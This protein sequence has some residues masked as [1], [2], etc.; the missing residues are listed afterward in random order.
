MSTVKAIHTDKAPAAIGPYSQA[1]R[2]GGF[3]FVS[4][5]IPLVPETGEI[6]GPDFVQQTRQC[7]MNMKNIL[8]A[9][10]LG[11]Q[12][13]A[14][15]DVFLTDISRFSDFNREYEAF[16]GGHKP[17]RAVVEVKGLPRGVLVEIKCVA[18]AE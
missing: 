7:L 15:V 8:D 18:A 4:G 13:V 11:L 16:F 10:G 14:A 9:A 2:A 12:S 1:I 3:L 6:I 17:A 5:Q